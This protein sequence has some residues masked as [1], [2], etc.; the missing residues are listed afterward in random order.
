MNKNNLTN[1]DPG[2]VLVAPSILACDFSRLGDEIRRA[3]AGGADV[4][5]VDVM[6][7]HF[8]P[9]LTIGPPVVQAARPV[10][11]LP[12]DV[13][14]M[15]T[16]PEKYVEPFVAAGADHLTVHVEI[17]GDVHEVL[18]QIHATGCTAGICLRPGTPATAVLPYLNEIELILIM[19]VEPGFGGQAFR[20]DQ[21]DKIQEVA[22][23]IR[24]SGRR[25]HLEVDGGIAPATAPLVTGRGANLLVAGTSVF[26][27]KEGIAAAIAGLHA[28]KLNSC[29]K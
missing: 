13:H 1:L 24:Q 23:M 16:N 7:G 2:T 11:K 19:T 22:G 15:I 6:D 10:T 12:F 29:V 17:A 18:A 20:E 3:E 27:A 14:L 25:I 26:R 9:N 5:H 28:L 8:V 4:V 21:L